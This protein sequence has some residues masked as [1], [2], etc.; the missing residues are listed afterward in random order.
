MKE[1]RLFKYA[2]IPY[3]SYGLCNVFDV[4]IQRS[5]RKNPRSNWYCCEFSVYLS[6]LFVCI[7]VCVCTVCVTCVVPHTHEHDIVWGVSLP[8]IVCMQR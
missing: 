4:V 8:D 7:L 3:M 2:C 1:R 5:F 6:V